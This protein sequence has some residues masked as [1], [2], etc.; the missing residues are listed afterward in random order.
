VIALGTP[1]GSRIITCV[2]LTV[3]NFLEYKMNL[4]DAVSAPRYHHQWRPDE[5][6]VEPPGFSEDIE[7]DLVSRGFA[8]NK[9]GIGCKVQAI[10]R[11]ADH[12]V[13]VSDPRGEG[14]SIG[15]GSIPPPP[16]YARLG[17]GPPHVT[18]D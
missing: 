10:A 3:L 2:A 1:A 13:G 8:L 12:W 18:K 14:L 15:H 4:W 6:E 17:S 7:K 9:K 5:I 16:V 11:E